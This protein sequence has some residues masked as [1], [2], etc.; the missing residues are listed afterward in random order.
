MV[1]VLNSKELLGK[2]NSLNEVLLPDEYYAVPKELGS[3]LNSLK[4]API[5]DQLAAIGLFNAKGGKFVV[6]DYLAPFENG[7]KPFKSTI[8]FN[9]PFFCNECNNGSGE[10][11]C[12]IVSLD[13]NLSVSFSGIDFHRV[14]VHGEDFPPVKIDILR[15]ILS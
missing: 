7:K 15:K 4:S 6:K 13:K 3:V 8:F 10:F 14:E 12:T 1:R 5:R 11:T 2:I 9:H